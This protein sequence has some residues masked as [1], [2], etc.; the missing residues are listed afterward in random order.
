MRTR[1]ARIARLAS[2]RILDPQATDCVWCARYVRT[3]KILESNN[4]FLFFLPIDAPSR[5]FLRSLVLSK[6]ITSP[7][8]DMISALMNGL[9]A[10]SSSASRGGRLDSSSVSS[11]GGSASESIVSSS[12]MSEGSHLPMMASSSIG[13]AYMRCS[14][15]GLRLSASVKAVHYDRTIQCPL[16]LKT[17]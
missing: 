15:A 10:S 16:G 13:N 4:G 8:D 1:Y 9:K 11:R 7:C 2:I 6:A 5:V 17:L 12:K 3:H 14:T